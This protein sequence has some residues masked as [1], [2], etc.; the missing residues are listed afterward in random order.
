MQNSGI[1]V[2]VHIV[3]DRD[4]LPEDQDDPEGFVETE[5]YVEL[6]GDSPLSLSFNWGSLTKNPRR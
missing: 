5:D 6:N 2:P 3:V 1:P 4:R